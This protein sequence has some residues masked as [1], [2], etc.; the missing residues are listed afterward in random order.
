[1]LSFVAGIGPGIAGNIVNYRNKNGRFRSRKQ[2]TDVKR[3]GKRAFEQAAGFLRIRGGEQPLDNP[4]VHPESYSVVGQTAKKLKADPATLV[5]N[6]ALSSKLKPDDFVS[7]RFG[8]P[9][10]VDII[11][12]LGK[13]GRDPRSEFRVATF[14]DSV[15]SFDDLKPN[16]VLEGVVTNVTHFGAFVDSTL[17]V[18]HAARQEPRLPDGR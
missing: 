17:H 7:D 10:I 13:P 1:M 6:G 18:D 14:D 12:G 15:N 4:A 9:T 3:L 16:P 2:L 11:S 5:G 8:L